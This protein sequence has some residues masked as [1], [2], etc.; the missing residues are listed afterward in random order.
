MRILIK[1]AGVVGLTAALELAR[2]GTEVV[3]CDLASKPGRGAS[4]YAGGM[5]APW[6]E[7]ESADEAVVTL[8]QSALD[9]WDEA[10]PGLVKRNGTL[11]VAP[12]R[13]KAELSR[14]VSRTSGYRWMDEDEIAALE[15]DLAGRFRTGL[16]FEGE[17]HL[18][19]RLALLALYERLV[20]M[21]V[22][23][24]FGGE[25]M[26][27][28]EFDH[29]V[30]CT[31]AAQ[32]SKLA[33]LRGVR[34]EMLYLSSGEVTLSRPVRLLHPRIPLYI[35]PR[36]P[37]RFMVG[38][39][40][41]ETDEAGPITARSMMELLNAAYALHP[42]FGEAQIIET[43][44]G[45]RPAFADNL[46]SIREEDGTL[47]INGAHRHGFL[48]SPAMARQAVDIIISKEVSHEN[49]RQRARA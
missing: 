13:D 20:S 8:G 21:G 30:D 33:G 27:D 37:G 28:D 40:M 2:H 26:D 6:C 4:W 29:V 36:E 16:F 15:P 34:G 19:P 22:R 12:A 25:A 48:L 35:V 31:G 5:L 18:D 47:F 46:P 42:A 14:F 10:T 24:H 7:R 39:T 41:I 9:W 1:G 38:A 45:I 3:V 17:G 23:F 49:S 44:T 43:G 11:V 32:T